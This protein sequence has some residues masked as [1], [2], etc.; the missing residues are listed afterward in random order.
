ML[1]EVILKPNFSNFGPILRELGWEVINVKATM[2]TATLQLQNR[3]SSTAAVQLQYRESDTAQSW[4][5]ATRFRRGSIFSPD[6]SY[7]ENEMSVLK[8]RVR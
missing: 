8:N 7:N 3:D 1:A 5:A 6:F 4:Q 2:A